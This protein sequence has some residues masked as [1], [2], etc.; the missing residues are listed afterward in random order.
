[1]RSIRWLTV[2][3][4]GVGIG[5][6]AAAGATA[7]TWTDASGSF[8]IEAEFVDCENS[9]VKLRKADGGELTVPLTKLSADDRAYV[10]Q[11]MRQHK[12]TP[13]ETPATDDNP[14][15]PATPPPAH[16]EQPPAK[17][18]HF[19]AKFT[20]YSPLADTPTLFPRML[21]PH[22]LSSITASIQ[23]KLAGQPMPNRFYVLADESFDV[24]VPD[25]YKRQTPYGLFVF[26]NSS[27]K[28]GAPSGW[29]PALKQRRMIYVGPNNAGNDRDPVTRRAAL[30]LDAVYNLSQQY[31]IDP[32]RVYISGNSGGGRAASWVAITWP[33]VFA[34]AQYHIGA[35][36]YRTVSAGGMPMPASMPLPPPALFA[37][38]KLN[39]RY[40]FITGDKD[41]NRAQ[42]EA[43]AK[44]MLQD[45]FRY[46]SY[47]QIPGHGHEAPSAE[48]FA[49]GLDALDAPLREAA[50]NEFE[51]GK[52]LLA[53]EQFGKALPLLQAAAAHGFNEP[54]AAEA[55]QAFQGLKVR[56]D[57]EL[58]PL[59]ELAAEGPSPQ[60]SR[61]T[62]DF[63]KRWGEAAT[64]DVKRLTAPAAKAPKREK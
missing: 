22:D 31:W 15:Q 17:T 43:I 28:G 34:G 56:Y 9:Q 64:A 27:D 10:R 21:M 44:G 63:R 16:G 61:H 4:I 18:G 58:K 47:F 8:T 50:Q 33:D 23:K 46:V 3:A 13:A 53:K 14:A 1:M 60:L 52:E 42:M 5:C 51:R 25:D 29:L 45:G 24:Y 35:N 62:A 57:S 2:W 26:I 38:A 20:E 37:Q 59:E 32:A 36:A 55:E 6:L 7:R 41:M 54:F 19:E 11:Q 12:S 48:W 49:K 39:H 40:A 30:A